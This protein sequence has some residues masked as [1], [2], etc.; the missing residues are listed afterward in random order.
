MD[1]P[2][3]ALLF[4]NWNITACHK[5]APSISLKFVSLR[6]N[7]ATLRDMS[8]A[9]CSSHFMCGTEIHFFCPSSFFSPLST[10]DSHSGR[11]LCF[12]LALALIWDSSW[13]FRR[14]TGL[15]A[16]IEE[17][18]RSQCPSATKRVFLSTS[19]TLPLFEDSLSHGTALLRFCCAFQLHAL[20]PTLSTPSSGFFTS[21]PVW[22]WGVSR[23]QVS[24]L[25]T[26]RRLI[27][28]VKVYELSIELAA[29]MLVHVLE[30]SC[31]AEDSAVTEVL[32]CAAGGTGRRGAQR[33]QQQLL[34]RERFLDWASSVC[35]RG[36]RRP[37]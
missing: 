4:R 19:T 18:K 32:G 29:P 2:V 1:H 11:C 37:C 35:W 36:G 5:Q 25:G 10:S 7:A 28:W 8:F 27:L 16:L 12:C 31:A 21:D 9:L 30:V 20:R 26:V 6:S 23:H 15:T 13:T 3:S 22:V 14:D 17:K 33:Q 34:L 24:V